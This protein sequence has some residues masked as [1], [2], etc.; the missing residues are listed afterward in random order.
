MTEIV[1][2]SDDFMEFKITIAYL[3]IKKTSSKLFMVN[4]KHKNLMLFFKQLK[5]YLQTTLSQFRL[6]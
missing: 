5:N 4:L 2:F 6:G 1:V 3:L